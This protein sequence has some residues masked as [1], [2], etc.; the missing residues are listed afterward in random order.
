MHLVKT[1]LSGKKFPEA[2]YIKKI[3]LLK[4]DLE[5]ILKKIILV[6]RIS[7]DKLIAK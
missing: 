1:P 6:T 7:I 5:L 2:I 4:I 3:I